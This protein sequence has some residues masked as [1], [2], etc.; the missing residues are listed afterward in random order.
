MKSWG[1]RGHGPPPTSD[2]PPSTRGGFHRAPRPKFEARPFP[3]HELPEQGIL[4]LPRKCASAARAEVRR[5]GGHSGKGRRPPRSL[6]QS[7]FPWLFKIRIIDPTS[8][9]SSLRSYF[10]IKF[11]TIWVFFVVFTHFDQMARHKVIYDEGKRDV[12]EWRC[13]YYRP[14]WATIFP[15]DIRFLQ[16]MCFTHKKHTSFLRCV[17]IEIKVYCWNVASISRGWAWSDN[18]INCENSTFSKRLLTLFSSKVNETQ[19]ETW[20]HLV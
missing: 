13:L 10:C 16:P 3:M 2:F 8:T 5:L 14:R 12:L 19:L 7:G 20:N 11:P 9:L 17:F 4:P 6:F 18:K 15:L 1:F